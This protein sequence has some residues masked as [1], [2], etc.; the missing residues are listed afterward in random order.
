M[1]LFGKRILDRLDQ[2]QNSLTESVNERF[3]QISDL[4]SEIS[5]TVER[6][7][8]DTAQAAEVLRALEKA[9]ADLAPRTAPQPAAETQADDKELHKAITRHDD[10]IEDMLEEWEELR[11]ETRESLASVSRE[12]TDGYKTRLLALEEEKKNLLSLCDAYQAQLLS[13]MRMAQDD[14]GWQKQLDLMQE[15]LEPVRVKAGLQVTGKAGEKAD[16]NIYEIVDI[17]QTED[18]AMDGK[19]REVYENGCIYMGRIRK[20]ARAS[21]WRSRKSS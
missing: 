5:K 7:G 12:L 13:M 20:K 9:Q 17:L 6:Q 10:A 16:L 14:Q 21:V 4:L 8:E 11:D 1:I 19:V 18:P 3:L 15:G 2:I